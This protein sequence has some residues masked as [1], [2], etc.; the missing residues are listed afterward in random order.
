LK[1]I[2]ARAHGFYQGKDVVADLPGTSSKLKGSPC[3]ND[4]RVKSFHVWFLEAV[5][6]VVGQRGG[7]GDCSC[8]EPESGLGNG[9]I[10]Q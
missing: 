8:D 2:L 3:M 6:G 10:D 9:N 1:V 7:L 4:K 5:D